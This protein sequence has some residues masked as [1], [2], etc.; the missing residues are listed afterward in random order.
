MKI[1]KADAHP[2]VPYLER[3]IPAQPRNGYD[4]AGFVLLAGAAICFGIG[5]AAHQRRGGR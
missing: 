4:A 5:A 3:S 1:Q 2:I